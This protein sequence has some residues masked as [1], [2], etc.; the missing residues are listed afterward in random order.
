[1]IKPLPWGGHLDAL[2]ALFADWTRDNGLGE[3]G[4]A[5][6]LLMSDVTPAQREWL[7]AFST[8]W[9]AEQA[10]LDAKESGQ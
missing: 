10:R 7:T 5:I 1:M 2:A 4:D 9:D 8:L 3:E 6:E